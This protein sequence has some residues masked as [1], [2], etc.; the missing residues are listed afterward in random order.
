M[1]KINKRQ[2]V[3]LYSR[4]VGGNVNKLQKESYWDLNRKLKDVLKQYKYND[5]ME[6]AAINHWFVREY[7]ANAPVRNAL[8]RLDTDRSISITNIDEQKLL[9][10]TDILK[11]LQYYGD[12]KRPLYLQVSNGN[13][14][15]T[16]HQ[17]TQSNV[18]DIIDDLMLLGGLGEDL[19]GFHDTDS[20]VMMSLMDEDAKIQMF[21]GEPTGDNDNI[22]G[23]FPYINTDPNIDLSFAGIYNTINADNYKVNCLI[24]ALKHAN[25]LSNE[26]IEDLEQSNLTRYIHTKDIPYIAEK[27]NLYIN[28]SR[29]YDDKLHDP[30]KYGDKSGKLVKL[31]LR[32]NHYMLMKSVNV[33]RYYLKNRDKLNGVPNAQYVL[34]DDHKVNVDVQTPLNNCISLMF[35]LNLFKPIDDTALCEKYIPLTPSFDSVSYDTINDTRPY[36]RNPGI[37]STTTSEFGYV[38]NDGI[39]TK[40][41]T[42][43]F[44]SL[45]TSNINV[46]PTGS[47][48]KTIYINSIDT[49]ITELSTRGINFDVQ[50][51][52]YKPHV[53]KIGNSSFKT[54]DKFIPSELFVNDKP[55]EF[56]SSMT[57]IFEH[58]R[59]LSKLDPYQYN[60][61][62]SFV[63]DFAASYGCF[64]GVFQ[65][66]GKV[67]TFFTNCLHGGLIANIEDN[68]TFD[69]EVITLDINSAYGS[70]MYR[71]EGIP[72][73]V[74][75]PFDDA[76]VINEDDYY[77]ARVDIQQRQTN[78]FIQFKHGINYFDK[79]DIER[80]RSFNVNVK[81]LNGYYF[82]SG[83]NTKI[84]DFVKLIYSFRS[85]T[86][87]NIARISKFM[88]THLYGSLI[89]RGSKTFTRTIDASTLD[90]FM[91]KNSR[92]FIRADVTGDKA[93][94]TLSKTFS[95]P[96]NLC[97]YGCMVLSLSKDIL[98]DVIAT[99]MDEKMSPY[100]PSGSAA[101]PYRVMT[102]S[103]TM[104]T[105][106]Y[107]KLQLNEFVGDDLNQFK[108]EYTA[109]KLYLINKNNYLALLPDGDV[110]VRG[111]TARKDQYLKSLK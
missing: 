37:T 14:R 60:S 45:T 44:D 29:F 26:Q 73:G 87:P 6:F 46:C 81:V 65:I 88:L 71:S 95:Q 43:A 70:A 31:L 103:I 72:L 53:V 76:S 111:S 28:V 82:N 22:G 59:K 84:K 4:I 55:H 49:L 16:I 93:I 100:C 50:Q 69:E 10:F 9:D 15:L 105:Q 102:D 110:R 35:E 39:V 109:S 56:I 17:V 3:N 51:Y 78:P 41:K 8:D 68:K 96:F 34:N 77:V 19:N 2:M 52:R 47:G 94:C 91:S 1:V 48:S 12:R 58:L 20:D 83:Y 5:C 62:S 89:S 27:Y 66:S 11:N 86:N 107:H 7:E 99:I 30:T 85:S 42:Y 75:I 104:P 80:L 18:Q 40:T 23:Y 90:D 98:F 108:I 13:Q 36:K 64:D 32:D 57:S 101:M 74:P 106:V 79:Y 92:R 54:V 21:Y 33:S 25:V 97:S 38:S 67:R 61:L 24:H 63:Q